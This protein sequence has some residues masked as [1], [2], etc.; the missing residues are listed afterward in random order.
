MSPATASTSGI[1]FGPAASAPVAGA[2]SSFALAFVL[3]AA[4]FAVLWLIRRR[5]YG[6]KRLSAS[7]A[8]D[9]WSVV[10]RIRLTATSQAVVLRDGRDSLIVVESRHGVRLMRLDA[11]DNRE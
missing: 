6:V 10:Q 1:P 11:K 3:L 2:S 8:E 9:G 7:A 4:A 5:G